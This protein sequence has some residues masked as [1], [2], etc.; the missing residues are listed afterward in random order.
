MNWLSLDAFL[1]RVR[2]Y[3]EALALALDMVAVALA[4]QATYLFRLGFER[5]FEARPGYDHWV[6][7]GIVALYGVL[8]RLFHV[9]KGMWRFSGFG[10]VK[11]LAAVCITAGLVAAVAVLMAQLTKVPRAVLALHPVFTLMALATM[12]MGY[13]MLYEHMRSRISGSAQEQRRALVMGA[14]DAGRLLVAGIQ[15]Q[16]GWVVVGYLDDAA[17]KR[18]ARVAGV[19]VIGTLEDAGR[20]AE[21]HGI[22]HVIVAMPAATTAQ[23][24]RALDLAGKT[25]LAVLTVPS[26]QELLAGRAVN[27]VRDIEPEDLLGREPVQL[28]EGGISECIGGKTVLI[29]GA[30]GSIGSE[31]CR[32]VARYGPSRIVLYEL[33][34]FALY[35]IEQELSEK[36]PHIPLVRLIG[37]VKDLEHLRFTFGKYRP[38]IV[39]HA[40]AYK[41]VP[42]MEEENAWAALRNNTLGTYHACTA[43]A[44]SGA[45]RFVL[46]STDKAVNPT[47]VMGATKR[48]A[49]LVISHMAGQGHATKFM[50]VRFGNV[51][52]SSGS[53]IPKFKEQIA[54]GGPVTVTHPEITRY[55]MTIPEAARLVVQAGAIGESGQVFVLD[56]GE[57]V[58]IVDLAKTMIRMSGHGAADIRITFTGLRPG[59]KLYEELLSDSDRTLPT[60]FDRLLLARLDDSSSRTGV[61]GLLA[62]ARTPG[63]R[64]D[65]E[66]HRLLR[67]VLGS[68]FVGASHRAE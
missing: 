42:L 66:A 52:G 7:L 10:E 50:A 13:R 47:N 56:M 49:E 3:R 35:R 6:M 14:G 37:D 58:R 5:W 17:E 63:P 8:L 32:Q 39:F 18:G 31:L 21:M 46:I 30:G 55:F 2:P 22:T 68:E 4:W 15:H 43:A 48:A 36:F 9:P 12:R 25:G 27:Q 64:A 60:P 61:E 1:T 41:H 20:L 34:E 51:L 65:P 26:S 11:R 19:P 67:D 57:P 44:E 59:E 40:A 28:D 24:R 29:T 23:R 38:Q 33:S 54:K 53:V 62:A 16:Q 45:E